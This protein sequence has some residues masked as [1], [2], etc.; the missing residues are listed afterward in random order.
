MWL[1]RFP[2][3]YVPSKSGVPAKSGSPG[4]NRGAWE[5]GWLL[6]KRTT[7]VNL[8]RTVRNAPFVSRKTYHFIPREAS[9]QCAVLGTSAGI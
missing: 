5:T 6:D 2:E 8:V 7:Q 4:G 1:A 9:R 3:S